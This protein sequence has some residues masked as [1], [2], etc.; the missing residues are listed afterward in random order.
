[1]DLYLCPGNIYAEYENDLA[2]LFSQVPEGQHQPCANN[3][4]RLTTI[5]SVQEI[6]GESATRTTIYHSG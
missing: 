1:M 2:E 5:H 4:T 6:V 3:L